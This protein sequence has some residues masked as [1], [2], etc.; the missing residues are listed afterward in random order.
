VYRNRTYLA[1]AYPIELCECWA[2]AAVSCAPP[3]AFGKLGWQQR[4]EF[5]AALTETTGDPDGISQTAALEP[6]SEAGPTTADRSFKS[7]KQAASFLRQHPVV[8]G[9]SQKRILPNSTTSSQGPTSKKRKVNRSGLDGKPLSKDLQLRALKVSQVTLNRYLHSIQV[10]EQWCSEHRHVSQRASL[11]SRVN[12]YLAH[13]YEEDAEITVASYLIYGLQLLRCKIPKEQFL[14]ES[15]QSL[16]GWR[17][18]SPGKMRIPVPEEFVYDLA[19][20][21]LE[22]RKLDLAMLL[23]IQLDGYLRP[24][25]ALTLTVQHLNRPQGKRYPHW[26]LIIAPSTLGQTTKTGKSDDSILLGDHSQNRW[27]RECLRLWSQTKTDRL[28][29]DIT[30]N[31]YER[32]CQQSCDTLQYKS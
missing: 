24:S 21:A 27:V 20:L 4:N 16:A 5:I 32:W 8:S 18:Q 17:R 26:S 30:L 7:I 10:F 1:G 6:G 11:D 28:F 2:Q 23:V 29:P 19:T 25:E 12:A 9:S 14:V 22:Q 15:K 13:L 3:Q 31:A